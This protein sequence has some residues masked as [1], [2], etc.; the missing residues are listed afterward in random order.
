[1]RILNLINRYKLLILAV[2]AVM[3]IVGGI[4]LLGQLPSTNWSGPYTLF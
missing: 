1:M 4:I 3:L 2:I